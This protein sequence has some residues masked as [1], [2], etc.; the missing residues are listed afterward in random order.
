MVIRTLRLAADPLTT[1]DIAL[2]MLVSRALDK[3]DKRLLALM[4]KRVGVC[5]RGCKERG[6]V[7]DRQGPGQFNLWEIAR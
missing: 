3:R 6:L 4:V 5:L 2:E 1:R 7:R